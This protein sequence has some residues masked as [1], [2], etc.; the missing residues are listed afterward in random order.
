[1]Q[2]IDTSSIQDNEK[3]LKNKIAARRARE[4]KREDKNKIDQDFQQLEER[5]AKLL[6]KVNDLR[7][8]IKECHKFMSLFNP[9]TY[10]VDTFIPYNIPNSDLFSSVDKVSVQVVDD[11]PVVT[12]LAQNSEL[13]FCLLD[14][15]D[16]DYSA[17]DIEFIEDFSMSQPVEDSS[18]VITQ[19][20]YDELVHNASWVQ[21]EIVEASNGYFRQDSN[22]I[23]NVACNDLLQI[24][25]LQ[26][27]D[28]MLNL[29]FID[30]MNTTDVTEIL[31][32]Q[33]S[34]NNS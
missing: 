14:I 15:D 17:L 31:Y 19:N 1:M 16:I 24:F 25:P 22:D 11:S 5:N 28:L 8:G 34:Y 6:K 21:S 33:F 20:H 23:L 4:K 10:A 29:D 30:Q 7:N 9:S 18:P 12:N 27:N 32:D 3:K 2:I 26:G 13:P